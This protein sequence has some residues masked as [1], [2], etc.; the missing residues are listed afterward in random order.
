[1][2]L[3]GSSTLEGGPGGGADPLWE[4]GEVEWACGWLEEA[5]ASAVICQ[6]CE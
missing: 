3:S 4:P 2:V 6:R 5:G 1:M